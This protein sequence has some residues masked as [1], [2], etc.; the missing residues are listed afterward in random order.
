MNLTFPNHAGHSTSSGMEVNATI[1][2]LPSAC[3]VYNAVHSPL[4]DDGTDVQPLETKDLAKLELVSLKFRQIRLR[5]P[6]KLH[7]AYQERVSP[8]L[9]E[10]ITSHHHKYYQTKDGPLPDRA[11]FHAVKGSDHQVAVV[12]PRNP[13][14]P[15]DEILRSTTPPRLV[16]KAGS[17][18]NNNGQDDSDNGSSLGSDMDVDVPIS[19]L[20]VPMAD[21]EPAVII[22]RESNSDSSSDSRS[23]PERTPVVASVRLASSPHLSPPKHAPPNHLSTSPKHSPKHPSPKYVAPALLENGETIRMALTQDWVES[24]QEVKPALLKHPKPS[25]VTLTQLHTER[26]NKPPT[27][28]ASSLQ[29]DSRH[30]QSRSASPNQHSHISISGNFSFFHSGKSP[31][32]S[33]R[34]EEILESSEDSEMEETGK[35]Q[36]SALFE[37]AQEEFEMMEKARQ[38]LQNQV[39]GPS[40]APSSAPS[41]AGSRLSVENAVPI[42]RGKAIVTSVVTHNTN[43][44]VHLPDSEDSE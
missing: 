14:K 39:P 25:R 3:A 7:P 17:I 40:I 22:H 37:L 23:S 11:W 1:F 18:V 12:I 15:L 9:K 5:G 27:R 32:R 28:R 43:V 16:A 13:Y 42:P 29:N 24:T 10:R 19:V 2:W 38:V 34:M 4:S 30:S 36:G 20:V 31:I 41:V 44:G 8:E 35:S 33:S 21:Q 26:V 6:G